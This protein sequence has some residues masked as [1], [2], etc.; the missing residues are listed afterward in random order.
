[1]MPIWTRGLLRCKCSWEGAGGQGR[2]EEEEEGV[3]R[4]GGGNN[5]WWCWHQLQSKHQGTFHTISRFER[6]M[7]NMIDLKILNSA[8]TQEN[9]LSRAWFTKNCLPI[10]V[11]VILKLGI[12]LKTYKTSKICC[13]MLYS[14]SKGLVWNILKP[15]F[16]PELVCWFYWIPG[17]YCSLSKIQLSI[18]L[19]EVW[20]GS[21]SDTEGIAYATLE[22]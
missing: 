17:N 9:F 7:L 14:Y 4:K 13:L 6:L 15:R 8:S 5:C 20:C 2:K 3:M 19:L 21:N 10:I 1:M 16:S 12:I 22:A 18:S 11:I